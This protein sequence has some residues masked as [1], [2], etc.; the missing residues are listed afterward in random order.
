MDNRQ[1]IALK[2][3][4]DELISSPNNNLNRLSHVI[5]HNKSIVI[6]NLAQLNQMGLKIACDKEMVILK[7]EI[8]PI[9]INQ[10]RLDL[11]H[12][13]KPIHYCL[14]TESTNRLA[15]NDSKA[16]I[17]ISDHQSAG[18]GRQSKKWITPLGQSIAIT[19][20]HHFD[21]GL[22]DLSGLNIAIGVALMNTFKS[23]DCHHIGL[24][25]PN[26]LMVR[27]AKVAGILIEATGNKT[28]S[29]A[30]VG[31][32]INWTIRQSLLNQVDQSCMNANIEHTSRTEF[33]HKLILE[34]ESII[35]DFSRNQLK[36]CTKI[37]N[38]NDIYLNQ[39][40]NVIQGN[41]SYQARYIGI[42][43]RGY[44]KVKTPTET[45]LLATGEVSIRQ[46][47]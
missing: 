32:G 33:I 43:H 8:S 31:I 41:V 36:N 9:N 38:E 45:K 29:K 13:S 10:L 47:E 19:I 17:Y 14:S 4:Y 34:L 40:I 39:Q 22:M 26:D 37:W 16:S 35:V 28:T 3:L 18:K 23:Y 6:H 15:Q 46:V 7:Q 12:L 20:S 5:N 21:C 24:K 42:D 25:W 2:L 11:K 30:I 27:N 1:N 44:L